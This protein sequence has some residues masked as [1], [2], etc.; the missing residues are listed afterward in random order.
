[1]IVF[2]R[3]KFIAKIFMAVVGFVFIIGTVLL[4]DITGGRQISSERDEEIVAKIGGTEVGRGRFET[5][6]NQEVQRRRQQSQGNR[7]IDRKQIEKDI[8]NQLVQEQVWLSSTQV[9]DAE[10]DRYVRSDPT[11]LTNYN[12]LHAQGFSGVYRQSLR[13]QM[14]LEN[15]RNDI[16]GLE[17]VTDNELEN[18]YRRQNDKAQ[19]K[20][21]EF[22][23]REYRNAVKIDDAKVQAY[24]EDNKEKYKTEDRVKLMYVKIDPKEFVS[25]EEVR[26]YYETH[27]GEFT[28]PEIVKARH[29]LKKYPTDATDEQKTEVKTAAEELLEKVKNEISDGADFAELAREYSE[30]PSATDGGALRGRHPKLPPTGDFFA[31]GDMVPAF[32]KACFDDLAVGQI[33]DLI[34]TQ[35]G[36]HIIKLEEKRSEETQPFSQAKLDVRKKLVQIDGVAKAKGVAEELIFDVEIFDYQEAVKQDQYKELGFI[37]KETGLFTRDENNIPTIG[38][39]GSY[40]GLIDEVFDVEVGVSRVIETKNWSDEIAAYFVATVLEK[41]PAGIPDFESVKAEVVEGFRKERAKQMALED[42]QQLLNQRSDGG[43]LEKLVEKYVPA[44]G[45]SLEN[46]EVK[47]SD[48][49]SLSPTTSYVPGMG[50]CRDAMLAAFNLELNAVGGP[51]EGDRAFYL[52]QLVDHEEADIEKFKTS[53]DDKVKLRRTVLQ[54][55]KNNVYSNWFAARKNQTP[56][57]VHADFR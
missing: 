5:L 55:K 57:E 54:S 43:S 26:T 3:E 46:R 20:F 34:E 8:V 49:F 33:S 39:K 38:T 11:L 27:I 48:S 9:T 15:L 19:L 6:V 36:Y 25:E 1:M 35:F 21:I 51:F 14:S 16:E 44:D 22:Q 50:S 12:L 7:S 40:R 23:N 18:E 29:I 17:L 13:L 31:R 45:V 10:I 32:E 42:A 4:F 28:I 30:G 2:L 24:F 56:T 47:E 41:K 52:V 37:V 53:P